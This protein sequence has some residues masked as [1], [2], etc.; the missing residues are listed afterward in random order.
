ME[1]GINRKEFGTLGPTFRKVTTGSIVDQTY[2]MLTKIPLDFSYR[3]KDPMFFYTRIH[4]LITT[5]SLPLSFGLIG[6]LQISLGL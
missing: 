6:N 2:T 1:E 5:P 3:R 4:Y